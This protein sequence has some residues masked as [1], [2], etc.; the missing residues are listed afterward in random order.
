VPPDEPLT[1]VSF[2]GGSD[3][4]S[5]LIERSQAI[6]NIQALLFQ[7]RHELLDDTTTFG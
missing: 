6:N 3:Y 4:G 2:N 5:C 7:G 1:V